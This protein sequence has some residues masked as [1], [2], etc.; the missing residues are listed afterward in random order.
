MKVGF[1]GL[2]IM[3]KPMSKNLLKAGY[4]VVIASRNQRKN[5]ELKS[6]G[7]EVVGSFTEVGEMCEVIIT[8]LPNSPEVLEVVLG[9]K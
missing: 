7:A 2:G 8:M 6:L 4:E 1:I 9:E 3:G 5:E